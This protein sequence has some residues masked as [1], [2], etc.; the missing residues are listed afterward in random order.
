MKESDL[1]LLKSYDNRFSELLNLQEINLDNIKTSLELF[2]SESITLGNPI[3]KKLEV[4]CMVGGLTFDS[5][6]IKEIKEIQEKIKFILRGKLHYLVMPE[7][8]AVEVIVFKW[9]SQNFDKNLI[10]ESLKFVKKTQ[11]KK[12]K[13]CSYGFQFHSDGAIILRCIDNPDNLRIGRKIIQENIQDLWKKQS[14]WAH[15]PLGRILE[16]LD[17]KTLKEL[18]DFSIYSQKNIRFETEINKFHLLHEKRWYQCDRSNLLTID[19]I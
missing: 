14:N 10:Q 19:L 3:P 12:F 9:P 7:N 13:L 8:L 1:E 15:V 11:F 4:Y 16:P 5:K 18:K 2:E 17:K 6:F